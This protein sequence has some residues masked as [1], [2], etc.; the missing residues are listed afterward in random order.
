MGRPPRQAEVAQERRRRRDG[1]LD[2]MSQLKLAIP[3]KAKQARPDST[4]R[5]VNDTPGRMHNLTVDDDWDVVE[6]VEPLP[7]G[8][9]QAGQPI[10]ARL[11]AKPLEFWKEDQ[12]AK[13][14]AILDQQKELVRKGDKK[15][16]ADSTTY[17]ADGNTIKT[18]GYEP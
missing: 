2:R 1:T 5:W 18:Q 11:C 6:G 8:Q 16:T 3:D 15:A 7:V 4:F 17:V 14:K 13:A 12:R 9:D 10:Y